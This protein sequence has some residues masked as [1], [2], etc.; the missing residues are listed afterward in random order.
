MARLLALFI[1]S[2]SLSTGLMAQADF[3]SMPKPANAEEGETRG[4]SAEVDTELATLQFRRESIS[5]SPESIREL[6]RLV[7]LMKSH[8]DLVVN[9]FGHA[10]GSGSLE[11][12]QEVSELRAQMVKAYL[13]SHGIALDRIYSMGFGYRLPIIMGLD[14]EARSLNNRVEVHIDYYNHK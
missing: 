14:A 11:R 9:V 7:R 10:D 8:P 3:N 6:D 2:L 5:L 4:Q 1:F 12:M 13:I